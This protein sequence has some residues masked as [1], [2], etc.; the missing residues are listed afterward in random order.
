MIIEYIILDNLPEQY[1][2]IVRN[3]NGTLEVSSVLM[4]REGKGINSDYDYWSDEDYVDKFSGG[5]VT[6]ELPYEH[7]FQML[8]IDSGLVKIQALRDYI[9]RNV[10]TK[11]EK[12]WLDSLT[13]EEIEK[14]LISYLP[15]KYKYM[16]RSR[17][18]F[19]NDVA[20]S[21]GLGNLEVSDT[22]NLIRGKFLGEYGFGEFWRP[23]D[24]EFGGIELR[25]FPFPQYFKDV[26]WE[27]ERPKYIRENKIR[28]EEQ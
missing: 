27:N 5:L 12:E 2:Y 1:K 11:E 6:A 22:P 3:G 4:K 13:Y 20:I 26:K 7:C 28:K 23:N 17:H 9:Y 24:E 10:L 25:S 16:Y 21:E 15:N 19:H 14:L 18:S 8:T